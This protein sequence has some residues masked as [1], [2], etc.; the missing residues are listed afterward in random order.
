MPELI[1]PLQIAD[2]KSRWSPGHSVQV[3]MDSDRW[4]KDFCKTHFEQHK[5]SISRHTAP[6]DSHTFY[7]EDKVAAE[8]FIAQYNK[9]NP[10]FHSV[11]QPLYADKELQ[12][13]IALLEQQIIDISTLIKKHKAN[14]E[15]ATAEA[16]EEIKKVYENELHYVL[17]NERVKLSLEDDLFV[18][19]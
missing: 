14:N 10:R 15:L 3:D 19:D 11:D 18:G 16:C 5:W 12:E 7:F 2:Y 9:R 17:T 6:D 1:T 13:E 4:G 8:K